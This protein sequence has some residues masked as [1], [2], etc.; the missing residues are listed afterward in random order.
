MKTEK[1]KKVSNTVSIFSSIKE[2]FSAMQLYVKK[3]WHIMLLFFI[4]F[5]I[6][7]LV[8]FIRIVSNLTVSSYNI[9][10]YR[11]GQIAFETIRAPKTLE[12]TS[13]QDVTVLEG[14][15]ITERGFV[16][17]ENQYAK[18]RK[19][20]ES[21]AYIDYRA[22]VNSVLYLFLLAFLFFFFTSKT[23]TGTAMQFSD[24]ITQCALFLLVYIITTV[25]M[26]TLVFSSQFSLNVIIPSSFCVFIVAI[27]YGNLSALFFSIVCALGVYNAC[28]YMQAP[29]LFVLATSLVSCRIMLNIS[30]RNDMVVASLLQGVV[31]VIFLFIFRVIFGGALRG[32][33]VMLPLIGVLCNGFFS[34]ILCLG[35]LTPLELILNTASD[36]RLMDLSDLN[37]PIIKKM[38]ETAS[39]TYNHSLMVANLAE[40]AC[41]EIGANALLARVGAYYHDIGKLD[42]P[43][44][45]TENQLDKESNIHN[46]INPSLSVSIIKSHVKK[47]VEKAKELH[48][49]AK[50]I[51]IIAEH[52]GNQ[53]IEYFYREA[54][55]KDPTVS[56]E[57]YSYSGVPPSTRE[58]AVVMLADTVE[59]ALHSL[60]NKPS[61][62]FLSERISVLINHK[63]ELN[64][65]SNCGLTFKDLSVI[66]DVFLR[67]LTGHYHSRVKY[68]GQQEE[69][70]AAG[71]KPPHQA[72]AQ[73]E[74]QTVPPQTAPS[75]PAQ[76]L[77][78]QSLAKPESSQAKEKPAQP[79]PAQAQAVANDETLA[80]QEE[81]PKSQTSSKQKPEPQAAQKPKPAAAATEKKASKAK[82][83]KDEQRATTKATAVEEKKATAH[84]SKTR[85]QK[86]AENKK[87]AKDGK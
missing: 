65:L 81:K 61:Y 38:Q 44:Y 41:S 79:A 6:C 51:Q 19:M 54:K 26:K 15:I 30:R 32:Y 8:A 46:V 73:N 58:S 55:E 22:F 42:N 56:P 68:P 23:C 39:G 47:G 27:L 75:Q 36:F 21:P 28:G 16:I 10:D 34:G 49:P 66:H 62:S 64:Q 43:E 35:F 45:F 20:A 76:S 78:Q 86:S 70:K 1:P 74:E 9:S 52:H 85:T 18:L 12:A 37:A 63:I 17:D 82:E 60:D 5:V 53:V 59:A 48:L 13:E 11:V 7:S 25:G 3:H 14:E 4:T 40:S 69:V 29:F 87:D 71:A 83:K 77:Q 2:R 33:G 57:D 67:I 31:N 80:A 24:L 50:V 72:G 84:K